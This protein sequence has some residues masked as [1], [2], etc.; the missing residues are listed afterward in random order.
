MVF[1]FQ[2]NFLLILNVHFFIVLVYKWPFAL[3]SELYAYLFPKLLFPLNNVSLCCSIYLI[4]CIAFER[5]FKDVPS[6]SFSSFI[7]RFSAVCRPFSYRE[8]AR[9]ENVNLRVF[10]YIFFVTVFSSLINITRFFETKFVTRHFNISMGNN[11]FHSGSRLTFDVTS[12][13][14]DPNYIR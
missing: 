4:V 3:D 10:K 12:L 2:S 5:F 9:P 11:S 6:N 13:R 1:S 7:C 8:A 14:R